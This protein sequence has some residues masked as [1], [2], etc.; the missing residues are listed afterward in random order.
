[1]TDQRIRLLVADTIAPR[2]LELLRSAPNVEVTARTGMRPEEL[3]EVIG[4]FDGLIVRSA[5][6]VTADVLSK[7]N[8]LK[9][10]G[11]AGTGVDNVDLPAATRAGVV[12]LNTPGGNAVAAAEQTVALIL[13]L[14]RN[15]PQA[16]QDL[17][18]GRWEPRKYVGVELAGKTLG[19]IGLG[20]IGREVARRASGLRMELLGY[21]PYIAPESV[22]ALGITLRPLEPLLGASDFV[23][24]H[25]PLSDDTRHLVDARAL[26]SMKP[27]ARLINCARGGLVDEAALLEAIDSGRLAGAALD[28][29]ESEPP[30]NRRLIEHPRVVTTPHLG[31]STVEAQERVGV[32]IAEKVLEFFRTGVMLD[33][34]TSGDNLG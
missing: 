30:T 34:M 10:I 17:R 21:D 1:M 5:T 33:S 32:E 20:R 2:G 4:R 12:V 27:G 31:A 24:L 9:V 28:V 6:K 22:A 3:E 7:A 11:R 14:A 15:L 23:T 18:E 13:A 16:N 25:L 29:F 26:A 19:I 8:R